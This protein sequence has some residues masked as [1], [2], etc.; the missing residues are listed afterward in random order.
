MGVG[1]NGG[2]LT[3]LTTQKKRRKGEF[4]FLRLAMKDSLW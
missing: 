2:A 3:D 4:G 1:T